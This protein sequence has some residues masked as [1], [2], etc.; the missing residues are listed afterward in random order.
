M[1]KAY[2][3][4]VAYVPVSLRCELQDFVSAFEEVGVFYG[5]NGYGLNV[6]CFVV[7]SYFEVHE[8]PQG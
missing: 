7:F 5:E 3:V 6:N 8:S 1:A 2:E 4:H